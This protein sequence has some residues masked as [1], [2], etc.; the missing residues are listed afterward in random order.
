[1]LKQWE[2]FAKEL[3]VGRTI[4]NL[5][6]LSDAEMNELGWHMRPIYLRLDNGTCLILS[7]DN[8]GNDGGALHV[9]TEVNG[10]DTNEFKLI[11]TL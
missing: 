2:A 7:C 3:L 9:F 11:P 10:Q 8:E 5:R 1:M 4:V 6:Y